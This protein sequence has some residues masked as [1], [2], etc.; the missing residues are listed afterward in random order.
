MQYRPS[1]SVFAVIRQTSSFSLQ[2]LSL[3]AKYAD[4]QLVPVVCSY[5][6]HSRL[7]NFCFPCICLILVASWNW[8]KLHDT[9]D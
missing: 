7:V 5:L 2:S 3:S 6:L 8:T 9:T 1:L 4:R